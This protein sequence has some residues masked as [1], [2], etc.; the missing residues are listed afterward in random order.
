MTLSILGATL[1]ATAADRANWLETPANRKPRSGRTGPDGAAP[2]GAPGADQVAPDL[3][4]RHQARRPEKQTPSNDSPQ[5]RSSAAERMY[6]R[7]ASAE[8]L[9]TRSVL[10]AHARCR[11]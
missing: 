3:P 9:V 7:V 5:N 8:G 2:S 4:R 6:S 11:P 10:A 1:G